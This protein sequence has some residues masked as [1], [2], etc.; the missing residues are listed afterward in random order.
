MNS[1]FNLFLRV[2]LRNKTFSVLNIL[3][4][5]IGMAG[6]ILI[7]LW[8]FDELS[9]DKFN[10]NSSR[11]YRVYIRFNLDGTENSHV[12][13]P[14]PAAAALRSDFP[15]VENVVRF[16]DYGSS[17]ISYGDNSFTEERIIF[18][19]STVFEV[20]T[21]PFV[22]GDPKTALRAPRTIT[23]SE[24]MANK[25]FGL[26]EPLGKMLTLDDTMDYQ[27]TGVFKDIPSTSHIHF[28]F[29]A[30]TYSN[31]ESS[32]ASWI[33]FNF[34]TYV[35][36][37]EHASGKAFEEKLS[38]LVDNYI[39]PQ[40][41]QVM[42][43]TWEQFTETG[44]YLYF[45]TQK[46][47]DIHLYSHESGELG[48][49]SDI[50]Y[51]YIFVIVAIFI[52]V[53]ACINFTNLS[54]AKATVRTKEVGLKKMFGEAR[55]SLAGKFILESLVIVIIAFIIAIILVELSIPYFNGLSGKM[56]SL[57]PL[58]PKIGVGLLALIIVTALLA[59][60]YPALYLSS[61]RPIAAIKREMFTGRKRS[62]FR[63][64]LVA[65]QFAI[66]L[67][68]LMSTLLLL[69]QMTFIQQ[70]KLGYDKEN[71]V[72]LKNTYLLGNSLE[73][74]KLEVLQ[75]PSI[76]SATVSGYL[77]IPSNRSQDGFYKDGIRSENVVAYQAWR[78]D[79][80][81]L[82]TL[83]LKI[84][85]GRN[86]SKDLASDSS[87]VLLNET[88]ARSLGW[89]NPLGEKIGKPTNANVVEIYT[90][91]GVVEDYNYESIHVPVAPLILMLKPHRDAITLRFSSNTDLSNAI[92]GLQTTWERFAPHQPFEYTFI[93]ESLNNMY[94]SEIRLGKI[95]GIFTGLAFFVSCLG[96]FGLALFTTEQRRKEIGIR[97]VNGSGVAQI[98]GLLSFD[99]TKLVMIAFVIATPI[100]YYIMLR[101]LESFAYRTSISWW[102][103]ILTGLVS[104]IITMLTI[105]FQSYRAATANPVESLKY[106]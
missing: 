67:I 3:G 79:H 14:A 56:L 10:E 33:N 82:Q 47:N 40:F 35:L 78:I 85:R 104:Y 11:I 94:T 106:E 13:C 2:T 44:A 12:T 49:N 55:G 29:I 42:G 54:T 7:M 43:A 19:D 17:I 100:A 99:F 26:E 16:R 15:E 25:Y 28:D 74:F 95:L 65:G 50:Q 1:F 88:A 57:N 87:A 66:S 80:N 77:P 45:R 83:G 90:V 48:I 5:A 52:L 81:Y 69:K 27:I 70:K 86:F 46:L 51:I 96:L 102:I 18:A 59:G 23:M 93:D 61:F 24:S 58:D 4:L 73:S 92:S 8:V 31:S 60:S 64:I 91:I 22:S 37:K 103:F 97:K 98:I 75:N 6:F 84:T 30:S 20:F 32:Q 89:D 71:L 41:E 38:L 68:L 63:N 72:V 34:V 105:G 101:W 39:A 21:F 53:I 9:Y 36:L 76:M 62:L